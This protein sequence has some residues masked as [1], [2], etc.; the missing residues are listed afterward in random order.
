MIQVWNAKQSGKC[1]KGNGNGELFDTIHLFSFLTKPYKASH[2]ATL[3]T[4]LS[5]G[6]NSQF[7]Q[8]ELPGHL[9]D[10]NDQGYLF[11]LLIIGVQI[12]N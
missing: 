1:E 10:P 7:K 11:K 12:I 8:A 2:R 5:K 6:W 3:Q 4:T 9:I